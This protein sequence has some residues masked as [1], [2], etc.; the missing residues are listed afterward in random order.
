F[1]LWL[2]PTQTKVI[3]VSEKYANY[4]KKVYE[5]LKQNNIRTELDIRPETVNYKVREAQAQKIPYIINVGEK[6]EQN[7]TIAIRDKTGKVEYNQ[8]LEEFIK[9][10]KKEIEE[11]K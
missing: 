2:A 10:I 3:S 9:K 5:E 4:A 6:E 7:K 8:S 1:P 11:K